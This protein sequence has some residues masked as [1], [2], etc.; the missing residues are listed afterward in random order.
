VA[1]WDGDTL[2]LKPPAAAGLSSSLS[3]GVAVTAGRNDASKANRGASSV[4][5]EAF[6]RPPSSSLPALALAAAALPN[7][8]MLGV[9]ASSLCA[10]A[11]VAPCFLGAAA[12]AARK[13][14]AGQRTPVQGEAEVKVDASGRGS[15]G[16]RGE[17]PA[18]ARRRGRARPRTSLATEGGRAPSLSPQD[19]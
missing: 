5:D 8:N 13:L 17:K 11:P 2:N 14:A 15:S 19:A 3:V 10:A 6:P 4:A 9:V 7:T 1:C 16:D 18:Q 12:A